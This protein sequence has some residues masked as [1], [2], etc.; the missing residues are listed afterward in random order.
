M[1]LATHPPAAA[2]CPQSL[3]GSASTQ[4]E[5]RKAASSGQ[6]VALPSWAKTTEARLLLSLIAEEQPE[7]TRVLTRTLGG[8]AADFGFA[9]SNASKLRAIFARTYGSLMD[10]AS[11]AETREGFDARRDA[12]IAYA[13][14]FGADALIARV[15]S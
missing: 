1:R 4:P 12:V 6:P 10:W 15:L 11:A 5:P 3:A 7:R 9:G 8:T 14:Q 13:E 2:G